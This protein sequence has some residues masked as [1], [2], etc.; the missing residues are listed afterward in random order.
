MFTSVVHSPFR[1]VCYLHNRNH[2]PNTLGEQVSRGSD[3][4]FRPLSQ[5]LGHTI[6]I[7]S[8]HVW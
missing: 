6:R 8:D 1:G 5:T 7:G 2:I 3:D 4:F